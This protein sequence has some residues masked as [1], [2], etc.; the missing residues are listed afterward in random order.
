MERVK[1]AFKFI[2]NRFSSFTFFILVLLALL[3][4][5]I[6]YSLDNVTQSTTILKNNMQFISYLSNNQL[7]Q[8]QVMFRE[9]VKLITDLVL[10]VSNVVGK[11]TDKI[12]SITLPNIPN[13]VPN[14]V[15]NSPKVEQPTAPPPPTL[16]RAPGSNFF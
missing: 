2:G 6:Y 12:K 14:F 11:N 7:E 3:A 4:S 8:L 9:N 16:P 15:P 10:M 1:D 13:V 5:C